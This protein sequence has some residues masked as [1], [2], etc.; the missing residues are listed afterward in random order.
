MLFQ[1]L[2][3]FD[4]NI[5]ILINDKTISQNVIAHYL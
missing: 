5:K 4:V 3:G 2:A 1:I